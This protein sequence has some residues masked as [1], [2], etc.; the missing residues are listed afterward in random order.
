MLV[1]GGGAAL[2]L[3]HQDPSSGPAPA[4]RPAEPADPAT[5][6]LIPH[7]EFPVLSALTVE[8]EKQ[9]A[10][11]TIAAA[12]G[13]ALSSGD[14]LTLTVPPG[15]LDQD[16]TVA[17]YAARPAGPALSAAA[18]GQEAKPMEVLRTWDVDL[19]PET[20]LMPGEME[21]SI[22]VSAY[23][24]ERYPLLSPAVAA[25]GRTWTRLP[26]ER[27]GD[28]LVFTTRHCSPVCLLGLAQ[29]FAVVL[30]IA[31]ISYLVYDR[32]DEFPD[33]YNAYA[34]FVSIDD[35]PRGFEIYWSRKVPGADPKTGFR[36]E[37]GYLKELEKVA[38]EYG[39]LGGGGSTGAASR[40]TEIRE[41][42][43]KHLMPE[44]VQQVE[45]A[46]AAAQEYLK[47]RGIKEPLL[48]LPVYVV[49]AV[50]GASGFV[51]N[52]WAGRRYMLIGASLGA[53]TLN[54][55][56][57]HELFHHYQAGY[58]W[59]DRTGH[60]PLLEATALLLE[61]EAAAAYQTAKRPFDL[62][63]GLNLA[64][65]VVYRHGL[66][67]PERWEEDF[68]RRFGYGLTWFLE[69]LRDERWV[70]AARS[71]PAETFLPE[72]MKYW[73]STKFNAIHKALAWAAGGGDAD[74]A[75][76][77]DDFARNWVLKGPVDKCGNRS[78]YGAKYSF[79]P[80]SDNPYGDR[81]A[82]Y[83]A[84]NAT[85]DL[86]KEGVHPVD[87]AFIRPW[88][89]QFLRVKGPAGGK[90]VAALEVPREWFPEKGRKR[91]V[92][93][94]DGPDQTEVTEFEDLAPKS[95]ASAWTSLDLQ[96]DAFLYIVDTGQTGS[97]WVSDYKPARLLL[98]EP[99]SDV[100]GTV[101]DGRLR[102]KWRPP[103][104]AAALK[105]DLAY[106][107]HVNGSRSKAIKGSGGP[108]GM[109]A[110][111]A[112]EDL[113][114]WSGTELPALAMSCGIEIGKSPEEEPLYIESPPSD[115]VGGGNTGNYTMDLT[116]AP[117]VK[118]AVDENGP[119]GKMDH[120]WSF[121]D[122][123]HAFPVTV[124]SNGR[125][126]FQGDWSD[127]GTQNF[128]HTVSGEGT[129]L[130]KTVTIRGTFTSSAV[131]R[132]NEHDIRIDHSGSFEG[133]G[134]FIMDQWFGDDV[135]GA[136]K[137]SISNHYCA[138]EKDG[139]CEEWK[140]E[141]TSCSGRLVRLL[142]SINSFSRRP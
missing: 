78:P 2:L 51:H 127:G 141:R 75:R 113:P 116:L 65:F 114:A 61:R 111:I 120:H 67:G 39:A 94:R 38:K 18:V 16:R 43:R 97:G 73:G 87:D 42:K 135:T 54:T 7:P 17:I 66:D 9:L 112:A 93:L 4:A 70:G 134:K 117:G 56:A 40:R 53:G 131:Y 23:P 57:L 27:R 49:P 115:T 22:D 81:S 44:C 85:V 130:D 35:N 25:D 89:I 123:H 45:A 133:Q 95:G 76:S 137:A 109:E 98:L 41:L 8:R 13:G 11:T 82:D 6:A 121:P 119:C 20:G 64:Q 128:R 86:S 29:A 74:L 124:G 108:A 142:S 33:R 63:E 138:E 96:E 48:P 12:A 126:T 88:S 68:V 129:F 32:V 52:P 60:L 31:A 30:P 21:L 72:L 37:K 118:D 47:T 83:G 110:A 103:S 71:R 19:G 104:A 139:V 140:T 46:L 59:I 100:K 136:F 122:I 80:L 107:V 10:S 102:V 62:I 92:L 5:P 14:G 79:C 69:Y 26:A 99:P 105:G 77:L 91:I 15:A 1:F 125:F 55:T 90:A 58:V 132:I 50:G 3:L 106:F 24:P 36:D 101:E 84:G 28:A 34:P